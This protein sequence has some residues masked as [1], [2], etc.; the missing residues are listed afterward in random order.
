M[1]MARRSTTKNTRG[2][3][4][5]QRYPRRAQLKTQEEDYNDGQE[6]ATRNTKG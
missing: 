5:P 1:A 6:E 3:G 2:R 4:Q